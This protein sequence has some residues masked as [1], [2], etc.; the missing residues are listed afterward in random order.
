MKKKANLLLVLFTCLI[1]SII[2]LLYGESN[3]TLLDQQY[4]YKLN[5]SYA[6]SYYEIYS[7]KDHYVVSKN[8]IIQCVKAPCDPI[9]EKTYKL[10][11]K[12]KSLKKAN[13][14]MEE[15]FR[16]SNTNELGG[17]VDA[18]LTENEMFLMRGFIND[19][20]KIFMKK[21]FTYP[22][23]EVLSEDSYSSYTKKG[24]HRNEDGT[25][26]ISMG[27]R[28]TGGYSVAILKVTVK[29]GNASI[30]VQE[31]SSSNDQVVTQ[32]I[33]NPATTIRIK[34]NY[35]TISVHDSYGNQW[36]SY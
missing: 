10:N 21:S 26:T 11:F 19:N 31:Q 22:T 6:G 23:Y 35:S 2:F 20:E 8:K 25:I 9:L 1:L 27:T 18:D 29:D 24:F 13:L 17:L 7:Y 3:K 28:N 30:F 12:K 34:E 4:Q 36:S 15:L 33:S 16:N 5:Y 32:A 14:F